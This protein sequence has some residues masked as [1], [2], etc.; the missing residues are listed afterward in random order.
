M[1]FFT[2]RGIEKIKINLLS[3]FFLIQHQ[4]TKDAGL[5]V[6]RII[7]EPTAASIAYGLDTQS[8]DKRNLLIFDYIAKFAH[9]T[10]FILTLVRH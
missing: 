2:Q 5:N 4:A 10:F 3:S 8:S 6:R 7:N 9:N 1:L